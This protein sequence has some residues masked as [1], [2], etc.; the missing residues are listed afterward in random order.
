MYPLLLHSQ[1]IILVSEHCV[2]GSLI[3]SG[4][5]GSNQKFPVVETQKYKESKMTQR[6]RR[7]SKEELQVKEMMPTAKDRKGV[8][9]HVDV[10]ALSCRYSLRLNNGGNELKKDKKFKALMESI[11][12]EGIISP[13]VVRKHRR[14]RG[15]KVIDGERRLYAAK[16]LGLQ[17]VPVII[18]YDDDNDAGQLLRV[19]ANTNQ[20]KLTPI[21]LGLAYKRLLEIE[22]YNS[23]RKL[24]KALGVSESTVGD[25]VN[26]LKLDKRI[27]DDLIENNSITDQKVL[28]AL[29]SVEKV[30][31]DGVSEKQFELYESIVRQSL[32]RKDALDLIKLGREIQETR[33]DTHAFLTEIIEEKLEIKVSTDGLDENSI[34]EI[35]EL[36]EKIKEITLNGGHSAEIA[37]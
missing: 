2:S 8:L 26:N 35:Q 30:D 10:R 5:F 19:I 24:A 32:S 14:L 15:M 11:R 34:N 17:F 29:R 25:R 1:V 12:V 6:M 33:E 31:G 36:I 23:K 4:A 18:Y 3:D 7:S 13:I 27:I 21:E 37:A 22:A 20:K 28:K 16:L 9:K